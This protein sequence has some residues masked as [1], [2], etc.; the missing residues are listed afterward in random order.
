MNL[1][2]HPGL[3]DVLR[4]NLRGQ[5]EAVRRHSRALS[6]GLT[7]E[8]Q[9]L[10]SMPDASPT[11]WHLAHTTWF[12]EALVLCPYLPGYTPFDQRYFELFNS[13]YESLGPRH[14][15]A[16]RGLLSRPTL[17]ETWTYREYVEHHLVDFV[18]TAASGVFAAAAPVITLGLHHEQQH[19]EL[20]L[21][22]IKHAFSCNPLRPA[23]NP[24]TL[25]L[26]SACLPRRWEGFAGGLI[27]VGHAGHGFAFD[28][29]APRHKVWLEPFELASRPVTCGEYLE[30][31]QDNGYRRPE[32]WLSDGW[33]T[34][35]AGRW[36]G[37][38]YWRRDEDSFR[39]FTL[40]GECA[41]DPQAPVCHLSYYEAAAYAAWAGAR[42]PTEFEWEHAAAASAPH[43]RHRLDHLHPQLSVSSDLPLHALFG[44]V[45]EWTQ[46]AYAPYPGFKPWAGA[47]AE[48]NGKFMV[49]QLVLRGGSCATPP[50][51]LR[52]SYRNFF[53]ASARWQ[54][55]GLRLA[56]DAA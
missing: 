20:L 3:A 39:Q 15:R 31:M 54:F 38:L 18:S 46:S 8:D 50:G 19:Q 47:A 9:G 41:L 10:Q 49:D 48:Y 29:E 7:A 17:D 2:V 51:H 36:E 13:Y 4:D 28:N 26:A 40:H 55:S 5:F 14:P 52:H 12:F 42:L 1:R 45:W 22:D 11:K 53:P 44:E 21:T 25:P 27:E 33:A 16:Q 32:F 30:F 6:E 56:R 43:H 23:L 24:A 34:V 35:Q 37:P